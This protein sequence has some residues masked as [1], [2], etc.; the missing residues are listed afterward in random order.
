M[1]TPKRVGR[2]AAT[3]TLGRPYRDT[4]HRVEVVVVFDSNILVIASFGGQNIIIPNDTNTVTIARATYNI[5]LL[6]GNSI[7]SIL[8]INKIVSLSVH[9]DDLKKL[10]TRR[11]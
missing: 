3:V 2:S 1:S 6:N 10:W 5:K 8:N 11:A 7:F 4:H 9:V